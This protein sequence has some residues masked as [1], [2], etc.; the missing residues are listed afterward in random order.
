MANGNYGIIPTKEGHNSIIKFYTQA[1]AAEFAR[2]FQFK[3]ETLGPLTADDLIYFHTANLPQRT[4]SNQT[5]PFMGLDFNIPGTVKYDGSSSW[6]V[7]FRCDEAS[8]IRAKLL[9]WQDEIFSVQQSGGKYGVP[10]SKGVVYQLGKDYDK[11][12]RKF[13][14]QG[15]YPVTVG[16]LSYDIGDAGAI[17]EFNVT[18]AYQFWYEESI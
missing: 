6:Q 4:I 10:V 16:E 13:V 3:I 9:A 2:K 17:Q 11:K 15:I 8:N 7:Q 12:I 18:F 5:V 1:Q 14:L